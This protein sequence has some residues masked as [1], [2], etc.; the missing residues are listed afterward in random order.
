MHSHSHGITARTVPGPVVVPQYFFRSCC[1][2]AVFF[3][4]NSRAKL[5]TLPTADWP[6]PSTIKLLREGELLPLRQL[7]N[8]N[9]LLYGKPVLAKTVHV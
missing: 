2:P 3:R 4:S 9:T 8:T 1:N 5:Y 6:H 7:S